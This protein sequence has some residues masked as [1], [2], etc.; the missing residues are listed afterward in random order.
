MRTTLLARI[1]APAVL[2]AAFILACSSSDSTATTKPTGS[3]GGGDGRTHAYPSFNDDVMPIVILNCSL[4][5][6]H[7]SQESNL[8][9]YLPSDPAIVYSEFQKTSP[10]ANMK[11]VTPGDPTKSYVMIKMDG[12]QTMGTEMPPGDPDGTL[13]PQAQRDTMRAWIMAGAKND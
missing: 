12:K 13:L 3:D 8:N 2:A 9:I 5:A 11:F 10:T 6:C 1:A 7:G 4:T